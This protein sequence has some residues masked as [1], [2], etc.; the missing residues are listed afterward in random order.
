MY[1]ELLT[2]YLKEYTYAV[3][4]EP[5]SEETIRETEKAVGLPF[6]EELKTLLRETNGDRWLLLSADEIAEN[7]RLNRKCFENAEVDEKAL[8]EPLKHL[9]FFAAN[10]CGDYYGYLFADDSSVKDGIYLWEHEDFRYKKVAESIAELIR[11]Y[12]NNE[13]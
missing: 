7:A 4:Q 8:W 10:G 3:L 6:P 9:L 13:V 5:C 12:Y 11:K 1:R 2:P